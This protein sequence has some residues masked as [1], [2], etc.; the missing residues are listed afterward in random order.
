MKKFW[1]LFLLTS[2]LLA[3]C[4]SVSAPTEA[5]TAPPQFVTSTLRPTKALVLPST[6]TPQTPV[7]TVAT[8]TPATQAPT[9]LADCK[10]QAVLMEDVTIPDDTRLAAGE[11][12]TKTWRF[13]NSGTC[14]WTDYTIN[15]LAGDRMGAPDSAPIPDTLAGSTVDIS[16]DLTAPTTDGSYSGYFTLKD[17]EGKSV[18]IGTEKTFWLKIIVGKGTIAPP[19]TPGGSSSSGSTSGN[20]SGSTAS[21]AF[22]QNAGYVSQIESLIN[23][24]RQKNG[25]SALTVD[26]LL[27]NA[28]QA[29]S[30]DM[31]CNS[32][33]SHSGSDG[34]YVSTRIAAAGYFPSYSEEIIYAG[35]GPQV[36]FDW[37]MNDK[38]HRD[39]IL[40]TKSS[41]MGIGY[42]YL[43]SSTYGG[44]FT[45]DFASP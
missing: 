23:A 13:K 16:L 42:A 45:V 14:H 30:A 40:N 4:I 17:S 39:A 29:H 7:A 19:S 5:T 25:L 15:F 10:V 9:A 8:G 20:T 38:L 24:E 1:T 44:Y 33:L 18:N 31:A 26:S 2:L 32:M 43:S 3:G 36:A 6:V 28:A 41:Q 34:S 22:S 12:F 27:T 21:C 11:T 37:W 35:G